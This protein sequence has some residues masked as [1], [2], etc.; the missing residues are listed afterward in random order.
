MGGFEAKQKRPS[1]TRLLH[2]QQVSVLWSYFTSISPKIAPGLVCAAALGYLV[3]VSWV[4][5]LEKDAPANLRWSFVWAWVASAPTV[6]Y[7]T[8]PRESKL[9]VTE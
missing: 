5:L 7:F 8:W 4:G 3:C 1:G 2:R 9:A 6:V